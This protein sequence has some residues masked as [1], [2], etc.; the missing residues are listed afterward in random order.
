MG[1]RG[2]NRKSCREPEQKQNFFLPSSFNTWMWALVEWDIFSPQLALSTRAGAGT[3]GGRDMS[4]RAQVSSQMPSLAFI[5][6]FEA[7]SHYICFCSTWSQNTISKY[8]GVLNR[9]RKW[10][11]WEGIAGIARR[12]AVCAEGQQQYLHCPSMGLKRSSSTPK[13][14]TETAQSP[15]PPLPLMPDDP[16][17]LQCHPVAWPCAGSCHHL[18]CTSRNSHSQW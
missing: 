11:E 1:T 16:T 14:G 12:S 10:Q 5:P 9:G 17:T 2:L 13:A 15:A 18:S 7:L 6:R 3:E 8:G 4:T